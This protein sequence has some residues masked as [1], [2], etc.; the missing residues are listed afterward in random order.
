MQYV[1]ADTGVWFAMFYRGDQHAEEIEEKSELFDRCRVVLP[2]PTLYEALRTKMMRNR[3][4]LQRFKSFLRQPHVQYLDDNSYREE[5]LELAF[6]S[7]LRQCR[8]L[9]MVDCLIR[10]VL[11]DV[12]VKLDYLATFN[13]KDFADVCKTRGIELI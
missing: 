9:S 5:A 12:N 10:L 1:L 6:E 3:Y 13:N 11:A 4:A 2:W 8:P 7:S